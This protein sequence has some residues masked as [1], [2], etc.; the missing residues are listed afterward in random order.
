MRP[1][2]KSMN[3]SNETNSSRRSAKTYKRVNA[4]LVKDVILLLR[5]VDDLYFSNVPCTLAIL[6][7]N[8]DASF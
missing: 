4:L 1:P 2:A 3:I 8:M 5:E 6:P 7:F